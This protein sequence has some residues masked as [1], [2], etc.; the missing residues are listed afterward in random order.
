VEQ[1]ASSKALQEQI[2]DL[3]VEG[4]AIMGAAEE[5]NR[6]PNEKE[7][8]RFLEI[9]DT[10]IPNL[11]EELK[12]AQARERKMLELAQDSD[13]QSKRQELA[14]I[15]QKPVDRPSRLVTSNGGETQDNDR[16]Y[17]R[18]SKLK[19]F[20][21][22]REAYNAG[23]WLRAI[24]SRRGNDVTA[25]QHCQR[26]GLELSN[27]GV[28]STGP[29]GGYL[30]P[31]P[32]AS[33]IIDVRERTG[34][35]R[36]VCDIQPMTADTLSVPK[37]LTGYTVY[38]PGEAGSITASD[39]AKSQVELITKKRAVLGE[40]SQE[41]VDDA[42]VSVAD[43]AFSEMGYALALKEDEELIDGTGASSFGGVRGLESRIG[44]A[45]VSTAATGHDTWPELDMA[46]IMAWIGLLPDRFDR[47]PSIICSRNFYYNVLARLAVSASGNAKGDVLSTVGTTT[48][49]GFPVHFSHFMPTATGIST[50]S[51]FFGDFSLGV[52][53]GDRVGIR[54]QRDDS[55]GFARDVTT[56]RAT[57]RYDIQVY[58][59]GT[60]SA[61]G[62][63]VA[64]KT[65]S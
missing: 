8:S 36:A 27:T 46:D 19:A 16:I 31:A 52:M 30:V 20:K 43:N 28:E 14:D 3:A 22:S 56:L 49:L 26:N 23:M 60:S 59:P 38:Y 40:I 64:L 11:K 42:L 25:L 65:A 13:R 18:T 9:T 54:L 39:L 53:L 5:Q 44:S 6:K 62:A 21:N 32:L 7:N 51:A 50:I 61:A 33:T 2:N 1:F 24:C 58:E 15:L 63:Y 55:V 17:V 34:V 29:E 12:Q 57:T 41:L 10:L 4:Q 35:A 37:R 47:S 45:G 48:F